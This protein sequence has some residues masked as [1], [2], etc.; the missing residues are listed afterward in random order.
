MSFGL[1]SFLNLF[2]PVTTKMIFKLLIFT[3]TFKGN[4]FW[5]N[6][7]QKKKCDD[8]QYKTNSFLSVIF[9]RFVV[10]DSTFPVRNA[11]LAS[12]QRQDGQVGLILWTFQV[13]SIDRLIFID[14]TGNFTY[15]HNKNKH[16]SRK[17]TQTDNTNVRLTNYCSFQILKKN[18][19]TNFRK[20]R[21]L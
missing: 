18:F 16:D 7:I 12:F 8:H 6:E 9:K 19:G 11:L 21:K 3:C 13:I 20:C 2:V 4:I 17:P 14:C 1:T 15:Q 5:Q 10:P